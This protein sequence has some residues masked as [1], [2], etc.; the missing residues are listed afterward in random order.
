MTTKKY[1]IINTDLFKKNFQSQSLFDI[2]KNCL[3]HK[4]HKE[5]ENEKANEITGVVTQILNFN[6]QY[7]QGED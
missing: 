1:E 6:K 2:Q 4:M 5:N 7:Q 3:K